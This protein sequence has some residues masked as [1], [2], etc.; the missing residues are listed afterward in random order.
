MTCLVAEI[1][2]GA[3]VCGS[4]G[5]WGRG[6][7]GGREDN[8]WVGAVLW[9]GV[10]CLSHSSQL[11]LSVPCIHSLASARRLCIRPFLHHGF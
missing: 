4:G 5:V 2:F 7:V 9:L 3:T 11:Q 1:S 8:M 10:E 6:G